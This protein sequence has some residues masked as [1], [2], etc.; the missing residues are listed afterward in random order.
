MVFAQL[1]MANG[2]STLYYYMRVP[3]DQTNKFLIRPIAGDYNES[4]L[5]PLVNNSFL[6]PRLSNASGIV[7]FADLAFS[8]Y[9]PSSGQFRID[10]FCD[11]VI[12]KSKPISVLILSSIMQFQFI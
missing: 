4:F 8:T 7:Q 12:V 6:T 11:G 1:G 2:D 3:S 10:Y 5:N 9:G